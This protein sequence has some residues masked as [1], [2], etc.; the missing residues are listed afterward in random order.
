[1]NLNREQLNDVRAALVFYMRHHISITSPRFKDYEAIL[2]LLSN[3]KT[4][5]SNN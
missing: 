2:Q 4:D 1:M 3:Y 5:D